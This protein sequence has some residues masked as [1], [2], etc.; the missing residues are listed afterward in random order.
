MYIFIHPNK[1]YH[2]YIVNAQSVSIPPSCL[3]PSH[4]PCCGIIMRGLF[5][6]IGAT[7][8]Y[9]YLFLVFTFKT[10]E[11]GLLLSIITVFG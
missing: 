1:N 7:Q 3:T 8:T 5:V 4:L 6:N 10:A 11:F 9:I 2:I